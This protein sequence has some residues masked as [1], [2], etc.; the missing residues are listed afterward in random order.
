MVTI[1]FFLSAKKMRKA[2]FCGKRFCRI[3]IKKMG[4][5]AKYYNLPKGNTSTTT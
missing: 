1:T 4:Q 5:L 2:S 3:G